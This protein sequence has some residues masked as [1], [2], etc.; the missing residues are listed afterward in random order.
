MG[1]RELKA[2]GRYGE[3]EKKARKIYTQVEGEGCKQTTYS[4]T[5]ISVPAYTQIQ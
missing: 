1:T 5:H 4:L 2:Q 3:G